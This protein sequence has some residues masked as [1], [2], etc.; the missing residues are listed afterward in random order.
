MSFNSID[1]KAPE[2]SPATPP[3][4]P[5]VLSSPRYVSIIVVIIATIIEQVIIIR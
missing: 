3:Q 4:I 2:I 1:D 5:A